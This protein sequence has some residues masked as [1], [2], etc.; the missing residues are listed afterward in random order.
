MFTKQIH[1]VMGYEQFENVYLI[2]VFEIS[3]YPSIRPL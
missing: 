2:I 3:S 1:I